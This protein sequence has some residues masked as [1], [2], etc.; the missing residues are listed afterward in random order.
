MD[1]QALREKED[2]MDEQALKEKLAEWVGYTS[3]KYSDDEGD[4]NHGYCWVEPGT[5]HHVKVL[6]DYPN[7][8]SSCFRQL[9]PIAIMKI[10]ELLHVDEV[11]A[12]RSLFNGWY[13]ELILTMERT[14]STIVHPGLSLCSVIEKLIDGEVPSD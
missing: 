8:M 5:G 2:I 10:Q 13:K 12:Y 6:P 14:T 4:M 3:F 1:E 9:V 7:D 11:E